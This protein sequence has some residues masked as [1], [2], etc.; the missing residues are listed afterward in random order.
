MIGI[1]SIFKPLTLSAYSSQ[2][3]KN[4]NPYLGAVK[5]SALDTP[6]IQKLCNTAAAFTRSLPY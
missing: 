3:E 4:I 5:L 1:D 6:T 2:I